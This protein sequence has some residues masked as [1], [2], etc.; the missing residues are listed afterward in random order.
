MNEHI[1]DYLDKYFEIKE[2]DFAV[3]IKGE[4]GSGKTYFIKD[5]LKKK[6]SKKVKFRYI[7]LNGISDPSDI[8][9]QLLFEKLTGKVPNIIKDFT[10]I[11]KD[12]IKNISISYKIFSFNLGNILR[13]DS[14]ISY[15]DGKILVFDDFERCKISMV[16]LLG[17]ISFFVERHIHIIIIG[18]ESKIKNIELN[19]GY[20]ED[21]EN[22]EYWERKE[23]VVGRTLEIDSSD[24]K[25]LAHIVEK[26]E[27]SWLKE[28]LKKYEDFKALNSK[29]L[30]Y[31]GREKSNF[32]VINHALQEFAF[33]FDSFF[34]SGELEDVHQEIFE[35]LFSRFFPVYCCLEFGKIHRGPE[36]KEFI[37]PKLYNNDEDKI[38]NFKNAFP[39][40]TWDTFLPYHFWMKIFNFNKI[41]KNQFVTEIRP[42]YCKTEENWEKLWHFYDYE[43]DEIDKTYKNVLSDLE[44]MKYKTVPSIIH[45]FSIMMGLAKEKFID[46]E[47][48][49]ILKKAEIYLEKL[50]DDFIWDDVNDASDLLSDACGNYGYHAQELPEFNDLLNLVRTKISNKA[51][52]NRNKIYYEFVY[53]LEEKIKFRQNILADE[54]RCVDIFSGNDPKDLF[55]KIESLSVH[56]FR[57]FCFYLKDKIIV[58]Q[59]LNHYEIQKDF[60]SRLLNLAN[61]F[62]RMHE[63]SNTEKSKRR[64]IELTLI[65]SIQNALEDAK[66]RVEQHIVDNNVNS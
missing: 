1:E 21:K 36:L 54:Y 18:D 46:K 35:E 3:M 62:I 22:I 65:P 43:D 39:S 17:Y 64:C 38:S 4:W 59:L 55:K 53:G 15:L 27:F 66:K 13:C 48:D 31:V 32:R 58:E 26:T 23:K 51:K 61:D 11:I 34:T 29:I 44:E 41:D 19:Q 9:S 14:F 8:A 47:V 25:V 20:T 49:D 52:L 10:K 56:D 60:W 33:L 37:M 57:R 6:A 50:G 5:F 28:H 45:S 12:F 7:S 40:F 24:E 42:R 63:Q 2:P 16:E 30:R